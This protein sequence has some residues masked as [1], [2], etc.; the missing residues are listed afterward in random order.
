MLS[1]KLLTALI[2]AL[3]EGH[4]QGLPLIHVPVHLA[5]SLSSSLRCRE[6]HKAKSLGV[7]LV[8]LHDLCRGD[9]AELV[10]GLSE[11][12]VINS[13]REVL[14][15]EVD[16]R[17]RLLALSPLA[18]PSLAQ[19]TLAL[20]LALV[21]SH[22]EL[23]VTP[24]KAVHRIDG[25]LG[26]LRSLVVDETKSTA[27]A[28]LVVTHHAGSD[29]SVFGKGRVHVSLLDISG[30]VL[31]VD[32]GELTRSAHAFAFVLRFELGNDDR[33]AADQLSIDFGDGKFGLLLSLKM[34]ETIAERNAL[35]VGGD[36][37][38]KDV[39][40][41]A[42]GVIESLVVNGRGQVLDEDVANT[43]AA[44]RGV[45]VRPHDTNCM[46]TDLLEVHGVKS[47]LGI[48]SAVEVDICISERATSSS[49]TTDTNGCH[50]AH[51][52]ENFEEKGLGDRFVEV[53]DVE[54]SRSVR[55]RGRSSHLFRV[56]FF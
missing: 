47:T 49:V 30:K 12:L 56:E 11:L 44:K 40:D 41:R 14:D 28:L 18:L 32:V 24:V 39:S 17:V 42:E 45:A 9:R 25:G 23:L 21:A 46:L 51:G 15:K 4:V 22:V 52:I 19:L 48:L 50:R 54:G 55:S 31:H 13:L 53:T 8:V 29:G 35:V 34:N 26:L 38:R 6:A 2:A 43:R 33:L 37:A 1:L 16:T 20:L 27:F 7:A 5:N 3:S 10:E 36:L